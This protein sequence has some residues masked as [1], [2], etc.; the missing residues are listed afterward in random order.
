MPPTAGQIIFAVVK[1]CDLTL[2]GAAVR[3]HEVPDGPPVCT[4]KNLEQ[5]SPSAIIRQSRRTYPGD[6]CGRRAAGMQRDGSPWAMHRV[7]KWCDGLLDVW[8]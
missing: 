8:N 4:G 5:D 2:I 7:P 6:R 1:V 3:E